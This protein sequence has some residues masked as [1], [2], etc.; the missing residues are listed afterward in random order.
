[1]KIIVEKND[2]GIEVRGAIVFPEGNACLIQVALNLKN[3]HFDHYCGGNNRFFLRIFQNDKSG[4]P[5][6][7]QR[8]IVEIVAETHDEKRWI[9]DDNVVVAESNRMGIDLVFMPGGTQ[10]NAYQ[11]TVETKI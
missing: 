2:F 3:V 9:N 6:F 4:F 5:A 11:P 1:M 7:Q 8:A 10:P